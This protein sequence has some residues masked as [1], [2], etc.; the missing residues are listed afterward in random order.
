M[1]KTLDSETG[2]QQTLDEQTP[3]S[4]TEEIE[5]GDTLS[6]E[7]SNPAMSPF[8]IDTS[9][10]VDSPNASVSSK[11]LT[12]AKPARSKSAVAPVIRAR[13]RKKLPVWLVPA[14]ITGM[15][16]MLIGVLALVVSSLN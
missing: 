15:L 2:D 7:D 16:A 12:R 14:I 10:V 13:R 3:A 6:N 9:E 5:P 8:A 11:L 4:Q 1:A